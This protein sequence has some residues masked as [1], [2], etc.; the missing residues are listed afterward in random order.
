M[1]DTSTE[2]VTI[3]SVTIDNAEVSES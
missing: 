3:D 1:R 2:P